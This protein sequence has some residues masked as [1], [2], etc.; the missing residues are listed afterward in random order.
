[1]RSNTEQLFTFLCYHYV[2]MKAN[3]LEYV[4][5]CDR[6]TKNRVVNRVNQFTLDDDV[7]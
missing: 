2:I 4:F 7:L 3:I 6:S 1:M 5:H